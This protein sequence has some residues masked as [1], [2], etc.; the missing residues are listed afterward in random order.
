VPARASANTGP[1]G[2][3][4]HLH[5]LSSGA[6]GPARSCG[7]PRY[8]NANRGQ[9]LVPQH[10]SGETSATGYC[11]AISGR[12]VKTWPIRG[13]GLDPHP[14]PRAGAGPIS[15][16]RSVDPPAAQA[17]HGSQSDIATRSWARDC[18][19]SRDTCI[20]DTPTA[21]AIRAWLM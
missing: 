5:Y 2:V 15:L 13:K 20:W 19:S 7:S 11:N 14:T 4:A 16:I 1:G 3:G 12:P 17:A 10:I 21:A 6:T 8:E 9:G 18:D